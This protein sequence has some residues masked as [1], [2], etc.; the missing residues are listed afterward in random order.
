LQP[1]EA[2]DK[3]TVGRGKGCKGK[4][5][6]GTGDSGGCGRENSGAA[7]VTSLLTLASRAESANTE[8]HPSAAQLAHALRQAAARIGSLERALGDLGQTMQAISALSSRS[9][10]GLGGTQDGAAAEAAA[11]GDAE[12]T[13]SFLVKKGDEDVQE[14]YRALAQARPTLASGVSA[15]GGTLNAEA[16]TK[17]EMDQARRARL[18]KLEAMQAERKKQLEDADKR[19]K[20]HDALFSSSLVGPARPLGK[21]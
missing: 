3:A 8:A 4:K 12:A 13:R 1:A 21:I 6:S 16:K 19:S 10:E 15:A 5:G 18:E 20:A 14:Q 17:D 11:S 2:V 9:L 7:S